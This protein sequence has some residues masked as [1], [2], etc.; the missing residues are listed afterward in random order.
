MKRSMLVVLG[1]HRSGTSA[2]ARVL[3]L[4][5]AELS[6]HLMPGAP[7]NERGFWENPEIVS[8][9][10]ELLAE[11]GSSW[12][13]IVDI[14]S[15][16]VRSK[17]GRRY[18]KRLGETLQ[19]QYGDAALSIVKDP[20]ICRLVPLWDCVL[21]DLGVTPVA[22]LTTRNPLEVAESLRVR[23]GFSLQKSFAMW[24]A[25]QLIAERDTRRWARSFVSYDLLLKDWRK[26][27]AKIEK[28]LNIELPL[29]PGMKINQFLSPKL[30]H[31]QA[32]IAD[33]DKYE[34]IEWIKESY[35]WFES[36]A[37]GRVDGHD[38]L[39]EILSEFERANKYFGS[40]LLDARGALI[41][42]SDQLQLVLSEVQQ[43]ALVR[44]GEIHRLSG[45]VAT[46]AAALEEAQRL[47]QE[48]YKE[49]RQLHTRLQKTDT[50][51]EEAQRL[52]SERA[53]EFAKTAAGLEE[54][55]RLAHER[56]EEN[57][58]LHARLES[59]DTALE[60]AQRLVHE[61]TGEVE[62]LTGQIAT[63]ATALE[64]AQRLAQERYKENRQLHTRL[65]KTDTALEEAQRLVSERAGEF[66]KTAA[67]FEE[68]QR[69]AHERNE[70][71]RQLHTRLESTD[72]A[73]EEAQRLAQER[74]GE[75][76]KLNARIAVFEEQLKL[77][78]RSY[79][80]KVRELTDKISEETNK[81][82][83]VET[84]LAEIK[85][86]FVWR[87]FSSLLFRLR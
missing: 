61:R 64:E 35:R 3:S 53:G 69:L 56:T 78:G 41:K 70:E 32:D 57:R 81:R 87:L 59:T 17:L 1:M 86:T 15:G 43:L 24:L 11:L 8:I 7:D 40:V 6:K 38:R 66:A 83:Q 18:R 60:E 12:D 51:L 55:Q 9:H 49:N 54:A 16:W 58:Q 14:G 52:V 45:Q 28:D 44:E 29:R 20:R 25:H 71:N 84:Q 62:S 23:N 46:T 39:N 22:I 5:G 48:R 85:R 37:N 31:H 79:V 73:L 21:K 68:A 13:D 77:A 67:G 75:L 63:T 72:T 36:T 47:A 34:N 30:K 4:C 19:E 74:V 80:D 2:L 50:A 82:Q 76:L 65:Q 27:V 10:E 33:L 42:E 26:L